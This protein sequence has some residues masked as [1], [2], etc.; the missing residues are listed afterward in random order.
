MLE[1]ATPAAS[2]FPRA[3]PHAD[4]RSSLLVAILGSTMAF[5]DGSVVNVALPVMQRE[6]GATVDQMQ[7]VVE[8]YALLLASLVL[9]GGALGD[10]LGRRRVFVAG[11]I[12]FSAS[13]AACGLAPGPLFLIGARAVQGVGAALLVPGSLALIGAAYPEKA[14]GAAIGTWSSSTSI[15]SAIGP[16]LGGWVVAHASWRWLFFI[17]LPVGA[18]VAI[19]A[20]RR[21]PESRDDEDTGPI[22]FAGAL[23]A[24]VGLGAIVWALLEAPNAGGLGAPQT[25]ILLAIGLAMLTAFAFVE[26]R[27]RAPMVPLFLFRSR[28]FAGTNLATLLL[29]FA[30]GGCF[31][32]LPFNLIQ[33]QH[34]SPTAA[35]ASML[36]LIVLISL[37]S[38]WSGGLVARHGARLPLVVGPSVAA[39]GFALLAVP[40]TGGSYWST[41][42]PGI[43]VLGLGMGVTVAPLTTAVMGSVDPRHTGAASGINNA[44]ARA[45]G[46][47]AIAALGVVMLAR[48]NRALDR[49]IGDLALAS[50]ARAFVDTQRTKLAGASIPPGVDGDTAAAVRRAFDMAF[51]AGFRVVMLIGV[52]LAAAAALA[53]LVLVNGAPRKAS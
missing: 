1:V 16:V 15:A 36:P 46:L 30:L 19:V 53:S 47:L 45:A 49:A 11:V 32:F 51:V 48:F 52:A 9:V 44:I 34:Y 3:A 28:T 8:A 39:V 20:T 13:S 27:A 29:Y 21:V 14:R 42:F 31:F 40:T 2:A 37:L 22:D 10:R 38:R 50:A 18:V 43:A 5:V 7:W 41:F 23:L 12:L 33:V 25:L 24:I 6:I 26:M 35:G 4:P 17:N